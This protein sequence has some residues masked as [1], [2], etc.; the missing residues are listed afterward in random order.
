MPTAGTLRASLQRVRAACSSDGSDAEHPEQQLCSAPWGLHE[1]LNELCISHLH[2]HTKQ[3][4][5][6]SSS[7]TTAALGLN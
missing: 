5:L 3:V 4:M 2:T 1:G 7:Q 6:S